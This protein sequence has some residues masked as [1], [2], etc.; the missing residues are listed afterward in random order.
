LKIGGIYYQHDTA[1]Y[2]NSLNQ[3]TTDVG[4][5]GKITTKIAYLV[6]GEPSVS[7]L[8]LYYDGPGSE[9]TIYS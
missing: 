8:D 5:G 4:P 1:T 2:D 7:D 6:D 3:M 9:G